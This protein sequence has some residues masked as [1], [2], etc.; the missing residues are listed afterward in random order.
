MGTPLAGRKCQPC[1]GG[2]EPL[3]LSAAQALMRDLQ[4][5]ELV[6]LPAPRDSA[7]SPSARQAGGRAI[8]KTVKCK[9]FLD[10]VTLIQKIAPIAEAEDHHPDFHLTSYRKLTIELSTHAIGG[11]S[12]NDFILAAKINQ[13]L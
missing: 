11:L 7:A 3:P 9:D 13:L 8:R 6:D 5:W 12:E 2:L 10:A 4:G 1:E